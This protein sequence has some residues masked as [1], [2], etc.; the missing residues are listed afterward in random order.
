MIH[1]TSSNVS[2]PTPTSYLPVFSGT[3]GT[4][5]L[6]FTGTPASGSYM[7]QGKLIVFRIKV[8]YATVTSFGSGT[9]NQYYLTL[10]YAPTA[11]YVFQNGVYVKS[12]NGNKYEIFAQATANST[13]LTMYHSAGGGSEVS[14][15]HNT[16]TS[17]LVAD[18]FN[19]SGTYEIE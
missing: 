12:S 13:T 11:D 5:P 18:Y 16:P 19:I 3:G 17:A 15:N 2:A 7:K 9:G 4:S 1:V 6:T 10:P 14:M 8:L